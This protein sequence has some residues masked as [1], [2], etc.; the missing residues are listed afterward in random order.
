MT[1]E[2][3]KPEQS[4]LKK[5]IWRIIKISLVLAVILFIVFSVLRG[6]GG[7]SDTLKKSIEE[8]VSGATGY[9]AEIS[10]LNGL[11]FFPVI[12]LDFEGLNLYAE[13]AVAPKATAGKVIFAMDFWDVMFQTGNF[14]SL[15]AENIIAQAGVLLQKPV[16]INKIG[17]Q[18]D[19]TLSQRPETQNH[20]ALFLNGMI[21]DA[22]IKIS[23]SVIEKDK[24]NG[25]SKYS[26]DINRALNITLG[27]GNIKA[28]QVLQE[29]GFTL[30]NVKLSYKDEP[31]GN[32][33]LEY[34]IN[35]KEAK[36]LTGEINLASGTTVLK[37]HVIVSNTA[38][39]MTLEGKIKTENL[40]ISDICENSQWAKFITHLHQ[41]L[42]ERPEDQIQSLDETAAKELRPTLSL[43]IA[44]QLSLLKPPYE[45]CVP[46]VDT[47]VE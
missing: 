20:A 1:E 21:E 10:T 40:Q 24:G 19:E 9:R 25:L 6:L 33:T 4:K 38:N 16:V 45:E 12:S 41:V 8:Y 27:E 11:T 43:D 37:P 42:S 5:W 36:N 46:S 18:Q 31:V 28:L 35:P 26:F 17:I 15:Y 47:E 34:N 39:G 32:G 29:D 44:P 14:R 2:N 3:N 13:A 23:L 7:N 22:P 30:D